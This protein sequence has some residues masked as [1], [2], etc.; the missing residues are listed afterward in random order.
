M[1]IVSSSKTF[2]PSTER[3]S[4]NLPLI[5]RLKSVCEFPIYEYDCSSFPVFGLKT[6]DLT[7]SPKGILYGVVLTEEVNLVKSSNPNS[8]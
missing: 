3:C 2:Y 1:G 6:V 8:N 4:I 7:K 5:K